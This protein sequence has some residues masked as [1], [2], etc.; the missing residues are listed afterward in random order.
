MDGV[1]D[2]R[3]TLDLAVFLCPGSGGA[4]RV[5]GVRTSS[6]LELIPWLSR[7]ASKSRTDSPHQVGVRT[8]AATARGPGPIPWDDGTTLAI[9]ASAGD[10]FGK[11]H[12]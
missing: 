4:T 5:V 11:A 7:N 10:R 3:V 12:P 8:S 6:N 2:A 1:V 9:L